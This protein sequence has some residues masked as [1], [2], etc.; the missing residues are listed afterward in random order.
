MCESNVTITT[1]DEYELA[2]NGV[3]DLYSRAH[4]GIITQVIGQHHQS[5][6]MCPILTQPEDASHDEEG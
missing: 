1:T 3:I 2:S 5:P 6:P 4:I